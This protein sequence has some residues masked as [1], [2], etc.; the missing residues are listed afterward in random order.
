MMDALLKKYPLRV[1]RYLTQKERKDIALLV[2]DTTL[3]WSDWGAR[4][5]GGAISTAI[6]LKVSHV[7]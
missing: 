7:R 6:R 4:L 1:G 3:N 2:P 5:D